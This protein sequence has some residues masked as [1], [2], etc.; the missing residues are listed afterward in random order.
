MA[1]DR[2]DPSR[3]PVRPP[4]LYQ[5]KTM[6]LSFTPLTPVFGARVTGVDLSQP[7]TDALFTEIRAAFDEHLVL[8]FSGPI[9]NDERQV[10]FSKRFGP[11]EGTRGVNPGSGTPFARQSNLDIKSGGVIPA[12]DRRMFYQKANMMWHSDSTFKETPSLCSV[13]TARIVPPEGGATELASTRAAYDS[14]SDSDKAAYEDLIIE[15]DFEYSRGLVGFKFSAKELETMA[16]VRHKLVR[17]NKGN[18]R[19][20]VMIGVHAKSVVGWPYEKGRALLEDL[21]DRATRP[22]N[23]Y[24]HEWREGDVMV[25]DNQGAVHRATEFDTNQHQRFM[26]RTTISA[27]IPNVPV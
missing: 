15:H 27:G 22:E 14:L 23:T 7:M 5:E 6:P 21:L 12:D 20:S 25:W 17:T 13:L 19:K 9:M 18:G 3:H 1:L 11:L 8:I 26:Q 10:D 2:P 24:R 4:R 16:P